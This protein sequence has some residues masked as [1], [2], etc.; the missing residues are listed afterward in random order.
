MVR[1]L[2]CVLD[3]FSWDFRAFGEDR[4][5]NVP[6]VWTDRVGFDLRLIF[7]PVLV[8][9]LPWVS[10]SFSWDLTASFED[11]EKNCF[12]AICW[13]KIW[14]DFG[15][16]FALGFGCVFLDLRARWKDKVFDSCWTYGIGN[17]S[18]EC[19]KESKLT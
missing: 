16:L 6:S 11:T 13:A 15:S 10:D 14:F 9:F 4:G 1:F 18:L 12:L 3:S 19:A 7:G 5:K 17:R 2:P 8:R